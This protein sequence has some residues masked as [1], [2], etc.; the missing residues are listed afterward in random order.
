M[1]SYNELTLQSFLG[2]P[3]THLYESLTGNN[4][5]V[6]G[7]AKYCCYSIY[8]QEGCESW[9]PFVVNQMLGEEGDSTKA[10]DSTKEASSNKETTFTWA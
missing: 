4:W 10:V 3:V 7:V 2:G 1:I 5:N 9:K 6:H 8:K